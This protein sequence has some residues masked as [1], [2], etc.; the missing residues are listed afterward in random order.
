MTPATPMG[1]SLRMSSASLTPPEAMTGVLTASA[2]AH[3]SSQVPVTRMPRS[4]ATP[5]RNHGGRHHISVHLIQGRHFAGKVVSFTPQNPRFHFKNA[6]S[7][8][9]RKNFSIFPLTG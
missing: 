4:E 5:R 3:C 9:T 7:V 1:L 2:K 6:D 8:A